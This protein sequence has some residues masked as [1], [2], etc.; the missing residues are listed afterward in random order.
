MSLIAKVKTRIHS[1]IRGRVQ[2]WGSA[3]QKQKLWDAEF[4]SGRWDFI[5]NTSDDPIYGFIEKYCR[6]GNLLDLG[7]GSG[8]TG[9]E[10]ADST[11]QKYLGVDISEVALEKARQRSTA[12]Q[13]A[14]RNN[15]LRSDIFDFTPGEKYDVILFR[16]SI[17]YI[18]APKIVAMLERYLT[19][20]KPG[21][22]IMVRLHDANAEGKILT[23][24][25]SAFKVVENKSL[26]PGG[27]VVVIFNQ[28]G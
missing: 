5:E 12:L 16:E 6:N 28:G 10:L 27:A 25:E 4:A 9:C 14:G 15:Y 13:R 19:H 20:L 17:Y 2:K 7:C 8:N 24:I 3:R 22:V 26:I 11:Y 18:P 1:V 21:G 23:M